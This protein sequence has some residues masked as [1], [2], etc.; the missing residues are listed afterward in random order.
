MVTAAQ[1]PQGAFMSA[2]K[3]RYQCQRCE[4]EL[5]LQPGMA[6]ADCPFCQQRIGELFELM[7]G[8]LQPVGDP[9]DGPTVDAVECDNCPKQKD[10]R[11]RLRTVIEGK[12]K[13]GVL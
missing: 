9:H 5:D 6:G 11:E 8:K 3:Q 1:V 7:R 10:A 4:S 2:T 12:E 13:P